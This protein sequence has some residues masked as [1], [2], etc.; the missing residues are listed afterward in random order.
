VPSRNG[1]EIDANVRHEQSGLLHAHTGGHT[2]TDGSLE[3]IQIHSTPVCACV[4]SHANSIP[5]LLA[6][7]AMMMPVVTVVASMVDEALRQ[8]GK[9]SLQHC[10]TACL[11]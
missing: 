5:V 8:Q 6:V 1:G 9:W 2:P 10:M 4:L 3:C 7:V 11:L